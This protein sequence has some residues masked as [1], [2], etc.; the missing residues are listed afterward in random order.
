[1]TARAQEIIA[2]LKTHAM[3]PSSCFGPKRQGNVYP[4]V[5]GGTVSESERREIISAFPIHTVTVA[6]AAQ[7]ARWRAHRAADDAVSR[8]SK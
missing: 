6:D 7:Q 8:H 4:V 3:H 2:L 5:F 1:M